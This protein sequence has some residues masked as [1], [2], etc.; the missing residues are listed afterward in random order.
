MCIVNL[1]LQNKTKRVSFPQPRVQAVLSELEEGAERG[2]KMV[3]LLELS[4]TVHGTFVTNL[5]NSRSNQ[6]LETSRNLKINKNKK[7]EKKIVSHA[8]D[9]KVNESEWVNTCEIFF[10]I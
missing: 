7:C 3:R 8:H 9:P 2:A 5:G 4:G 10:K 6:S 1:H